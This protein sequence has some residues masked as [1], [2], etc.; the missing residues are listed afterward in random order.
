MYTH[1]RT[2][3]RTHIHT[4][5]HTLSYESSIYIC[6]Q[7]YIYIC[8]DVQTHIYVYICHICVTGLHKRFDLKGSTLG[9]FASLSDKAKGARAILKG[10][11]TKKNVKVN[12]QE[13]RPFE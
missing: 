11:C 6:I 7:V 12:L 9:R 1:T 5:T 10:N 8:T 4:P 2:H 3:T 13:A